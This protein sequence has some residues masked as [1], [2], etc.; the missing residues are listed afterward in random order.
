MTNL[1]KSE[2]RNTRVKRR[3]ARTKIKPLKYWCNEWR[4]FNIH[5]ELI[6]D[7]SP[8]SEAQD[9]SYSQ[10]RKTKRRD[11]EKPITDDSSPCS[12][13]QDVPYSQKR[14][15]KRRDVEKPITDDSSSSVKAQDVFCSPERKTRLIVVETPV[16]DNLSSYALRNQTNKTE[17]EAQPGNITSTL[18]NEIPKIIIEKIL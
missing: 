4:K 12:E 14:K 17:L 8:S 18:I 6:Y 16:K 13:V 7:S 9:V 5:G 10:K 15:T 11:V 1:G 2:N 3:S